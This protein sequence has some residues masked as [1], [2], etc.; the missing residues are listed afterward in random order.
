[1]SRLGG[2]NQMAPSARAGAKRLT[3]SMGLHL[4]RRAITSKATRGAGTVRWMGSRQ[5]RAVAPPM[6]VQAAAQSAPQPPTRGRPT[7]FLRTALTRLRRR[8]ACGAIRMGILAPRTSTATSACRQQ[9][10]AGSREAC[11]RRTATESSQTM[12][13]MRKATQR[14]S[15]E[16]SHAVRAVGGCIDARFAIRSVGCCLRARRSC[17][18][19][20]CGLSKALVWRD[21]SDF[22]AWSTPPALR[23]WSRV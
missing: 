12:R 5:K 19:S 10:E 11:G 22:T 23:L 9:V 6:H 16:P 13:G 21:G 7:L 3:I 8:V 15:M 1:M 2:A 20:A 4:W 17:D 14:R 18:S